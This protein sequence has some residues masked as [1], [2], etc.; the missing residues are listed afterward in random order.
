MEKSTIFSPADDCLVELKDVKKTFGTKVV[1]DGVTLRIPR[2]KIS[3]IIG[4]S[5][6][7]KSVT[8]KH[9]VGVLKC[10]SGEIYLHHKP[11]S[12]ASARDWEEELKKI[13]ILFQ[14]GALFD[15]LSVFENVSFPIVNH[16]KI[17]TEKLAA[18][19]ADLLSMV[20][21][22]G[23][24]SKYP[25]ELSIGERKRVGLARALALQPDILLYDEPTTSMD[26]LVSDLIDHLI[27]DTQRRNPS[28]TSVVIS[29]DIASVMS[30]ADY[31]FFL[32]EGKIYFQGTPQDFRDSKDEAVVQFL[33]G[34]LQG[35]L[36][37]PLV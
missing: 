6:E 22:S 2:G 13:G 18:C 37:V 35:P 7:G 3:F 34:S 10:D 31:I 23:I 19:V 25:G 16:K 5:G 4:R 32:H 8:I 30:V 33:T 14:D 36:M 12:R 28:M 29:H 21:L 26:P 17:T 1:L 27:L 20:G 9:I 15:S 11:M 24:E